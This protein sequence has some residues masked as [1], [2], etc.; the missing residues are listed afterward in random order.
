MDQY[1]QLIFIGYTN[2][3]TN[4][5]PTKKTVF[6]GGAAYFAAIAASRIIQ[7]IG[8]VTRVG[9]DFDLSFLKTRVLAQGIRI[10]SRGKTAISTQMYHS[11]T[12]LTDRDISVSLGVAPGLTPKDIPT[13][14]LSRAQRIHIA[15]MPPVQ[16]RHFIEFLKEKTPQAKLSIDTDIFLLK[17]KK[18]KKLVEENFTLVNTVFANRREYQELKFTI[19]RLNEAIIKLD[20]EGALY[21]KKGHTVFRCPAPVVQAI[22]TTGAGDIF[23]GTFLAAQALGT[24][25]KESLKKATETASASVTEVSI[26]HLFS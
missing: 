26:N 6:P 1:P 17:E 2:I 5:T 14:W 23:A 3:D 7:P 24:S 25:I 15:T 11:E 16:Q 19:D 10:V 4:I 12:D 8:L 18:T 9:E 20:K 21:L 13:H 22:D